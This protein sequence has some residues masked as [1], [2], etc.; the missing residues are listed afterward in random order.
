MSKRERQ[1]H[2][3]QEVLNEQIELGNPSKSRTKHKGNIKPKKSSTVIFVT[4]GR[5]L[6]ILKW[7][8]LR[9]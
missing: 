5:E 9:S 1:R 8:D 6:G 2:T 3:Q 4:L 7:I